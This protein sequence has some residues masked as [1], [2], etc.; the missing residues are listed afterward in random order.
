[1][2]IWICN[3]KCGGPDITGLKNG[4]RLTIKKESIFFPNNLLHFVLLFERGKG[5]VE[6]LE[7]GAANVSK[8]A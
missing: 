2:K 8:A 7:S 3:L 5:Y 6:Y 4:K 1:M